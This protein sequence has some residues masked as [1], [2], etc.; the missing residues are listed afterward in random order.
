MYLIMLT[1]GVL[2]VSLYPVGA[3]MVLP[4]EDRTASSLVFAIL[5]IGVVLQSGYR[6]FFGI[7]LQ[8]GY[9]GTHTCLAAT[10]VGVSVV[11]NICLIPLFGIYGAAIATALGLLFEA[12]AISWLSRACLAV[13]L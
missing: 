3:G 13:R 1:L 6:P 8:A 11:C 4:R 2:A 10:V 9:P 12:V 5:M 7:L